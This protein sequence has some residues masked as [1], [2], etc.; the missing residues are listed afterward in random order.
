MTSFYENNTNYDNIT[1]SLI[2]KQLNPP[3]FRFHK[4]TSSY[5][6]TV[7]S[8][9]IHLTIDVH[10]LGTIR[11]YFIYNIN[12]KICKYKDSFYSEKQRIK[13][14]KKNIKKKKLVILQRQNIGK[15]IMKTILNK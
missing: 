11:Q 4:F 6:G 14:R 15:E 12:N 1:K 13:D 7:L 10:G 5:L 9:G 8:R 2:F 3:Q